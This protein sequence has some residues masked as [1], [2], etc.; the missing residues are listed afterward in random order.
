MRHSG[1]RN[2]A[3]DACGEP[4]LGY[5]PRRRVASGQPVGS[6]QEKSARRPQNPVPKR[7]RSKE[8]TFRDTHTREH[9]PLTGR[10]L[11]QE[12]ETLRA[13]GTLIQPLAHHRASLGL[14]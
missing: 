13:V 8:H 4:A 10:V 12:E 11:H 3:S 1:T 5:R 14:G 9:G 6:M 2:P 7:T